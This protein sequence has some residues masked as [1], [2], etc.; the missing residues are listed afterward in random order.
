MTA[1][2]NQHHNNGIDSINCPIVRQPGLG[3]YEASLCL[4]RR[5]VRCDDAAWQLCEGAALASKDHAVVPKALS[6]CSAFH[7]AAKSLAKLGLL[8][9]LLL[10][11][12]TK[13]KV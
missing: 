1:D 2:G 9:L 10:T 13:L 12:V 5:L 11:S 7:A 3:V 4:P 8:G 6:G